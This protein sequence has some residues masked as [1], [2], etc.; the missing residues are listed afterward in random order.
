MVIEQDTFNRDDEETADGGERAD[1]EVVADEANYM[2]DRDDEETVDGGVEAAADKE[3][4]AGADETENRDDEETADGGERADDEAAA[5]DGDRAEDGEEEA[6][7]EEDKL[8]QPEYK[9]VIVGGFVAAAWEE[10]WHIGEVVGK[11][12]EV[13][14]VKYLKSNGRSGTFKWS[15][16]VSPTDLDQIILTA[17][18]MQA[19]SSGR[20]FK[21]TSN[22]A[23]V[24]Q[25]NNIY[26]LYS[27]KF[28]D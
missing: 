25:I 22:S 16:E 7:D 24:K 23:T 11:K 14:T 18:G 2:E 28:Y 5:A 1:D 26:S 12:E 27:K 6:E 3:A 10:G 4:D 21:M 17:I 13:V 9:D 20:T 8:K 15:G 19:S